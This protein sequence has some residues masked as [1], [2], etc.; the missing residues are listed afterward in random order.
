[1]GKSSI[2]KLV[3]W[4]LFIPA[5]T[6][7]LVM[8]T[9][10]WCGN[11][12]LSVGTI[13]LVA[14]VV[15]LIL[16]AW[17]IFIKVTINNL[18]SRAQE[19]FVAD[20]NALHQLENMKLTGLSN[21]DDI[22]SNLAKMAGVSISQVETLSEEVQTNNKKMALDAATI[23]KLELE[24]SGNNQKNKDMH[25]ALSEKSKLL[26]DV[27]A[28]LELLTQAIGLSLEEFMVI[29]DSN[30]NILYMN[31]KA[32]QIPNIESVIVELKKNSKIINMVDCQGVVEFR[33]L[34][35]DT[36]VYR[37][38]KTDARNDGKIL[39]MHHDSIKA[40]LLNNQAMF[41]RIIDQLKSMSSE[42]SG[43]V[44]S[45]I[46]G[47]KLIDSTLVETMELVECVGGAVD[48]TRALKDRS[49]EIS[50]IMALITDL[51]DRTNL[52]A[53]NAAI[54][55]ARAGEHGK[56]FAVV[57]IE[58]RKLAENTQKAIKDI[59]V[60]V[61]SMQQETDTIRETT[62]AIN[63]IVAKNKASIDRLAENI[64]TYRNSA[65]LSMRDTLVLSNYTFA[66]LAKVDHVIYKN[67]VYS[68]IFGEQNEFN[69][70]AHHECRLG[71]WYHDDGKVLY[72][73]TDGYAKLDAPH[74][75]VHKEANELAKK[76]VGSKVMCSKEEIENAVRNIE[77]A[78]L[79]VFKIIDNMIEEKIH[80]I[81]S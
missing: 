81:Q 53:L 68:L 76:C 47:M 31:D 22:L 15:A 36:V 61:K 19:C 70:T 40:A 80:D 25:N 41:V 45:S 24:L 67:N 56:G 62:E 35:N 58:V 17:F 10:V 30:S 42:S 59:E 51:A 1:M 79:E 65:E 6:G 3:Y 66:S 64:N 32:S 11:S 28:R 16:V 50:N 12:P 21:V 5:V 52:L 9:I 71:K 26:E 77:R 39:T 43:M 23:Q 38:R 13:F 34:P 74:S 55:A 75:I 18:S 44:N 72:G 69:E 48:S 60:V 20:R 49:G 33:K 57:A 78:S 4:S 63:E 29:L 7:V 8:T 46:D 27:E 37:F 2:A 14:I 73:K 54:E